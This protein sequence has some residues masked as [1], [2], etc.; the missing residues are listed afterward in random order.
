LSRRN[1]PPASSDRI[2]TRR[3]QEGLDAAAAASLRAGSRGTWPTVLELAREVRAALSPAL[4][5]EAVGSSNPDVRA[6][7]YWHLALDL[8]RGR[9]LPADVVSALGR[10]REATSPE[11][12]DASA[13]FP[14][15]LL[16]RARKAPGP[17]EDWEARA[18]AAVRVSTL[19]EG[20]RAA[21]GTLLT[22]AEAR[23]ISLRMTHGADGKMFERAAARE[24]E[25]GSGEYGGL[26]FAA[27][28]PPGTLRDL[29]VVTGCKP[30]E[31]VRA[32][33]IVEYAPDGRPRRISVDHA[34]LTTGCAQAAGPAIGMTLAPP[35]LADAANPAR[36]TVVIIPLDKEAL[37]CA[38]EPE[39]SAPEPVTHGEE[40]G[41]P[42]VVKE[43]RKLKNVPPV[44]PARAMAEQ[45]QGQVILDA[46]ISPTGCIRSVRVSRS[47][48]PDLDAAAMIAVGQWRY[49]P[50]LLRGTPVPVLM[51]VTVNF[52]LSR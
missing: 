10:A 12:A 15:L 11:P 31:G 35:D 29:L 24:P 25:A 17:G 36:R 4:L 5:V 39:P 13:A 49:T 3:G 9:P 34:G 7:T 50:T 51:T 37:A 19:K 16:Q 45:R 14:F 18:A 41:G 27:G 6:A 40:P 42:S 21:L 33:G 28:L 46:V 30:G 23:A 44:Y 48:A 2:A 1:A 38:D 20:D 52:R 43:P 22:A 26:S 8:A 32:W 47:V